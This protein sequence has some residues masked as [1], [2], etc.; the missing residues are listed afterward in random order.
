MRC[1][2]NADVIFFPV[3]LRQSSLESTASHKSS[4]IPTLDGLR[5]IAFFFVFLAHTTTASITHLFP[6]RLGVTLFFFLSGYLITTLLREEAAKTGTISLKDFYLRRA[7]RI[8]IPMYIAYAAVS[9]SSLLFSFP[10]GSLKGFASAI[11]YYYNYA[12]MISSHA[13][14]PPGFS[15]IWSLSVEEHFYIFFPLLFL[16]WTK[17][18]LQSE[19]KIRIIL[20][21]CVAGVLWRTYVSLHEFPDLWTY[22]ATDCRFDSLLWGSLLAIWNNPRL[23]TP[24]KVL[25][26]RCG[27]LASLALA[28]IAGDFLIR[29]VV[30]RD[31]MRY[32]VQG[33]ALYFIFYFAIAH[34]EHWSVRW[35]EN[36][37]LRYIGWLS[38]S[39]YLIHLPIQIVLHRYLSHTEWLICPICLLLS[40]AYAIPL[41]HWVELPIQRLR[42]RLRHSGPPISPDLLTKGL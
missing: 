24:A 30:Y 21:L 15:V 31:G 33:I 27:L 17:K 8:F 5:A 41:R 4:Y 20:S 19:T 6:Q 7:L 29:S 42:A 14:V 38:Y 25:Q 13:T 23:D 9:L 2:A 39:L 28:V 12:Q 18:H 16:L 11:F 22:T 26:R 35:L 1:R 10:I 37:Q 36:K 32:T 3:S 40:L 34:P